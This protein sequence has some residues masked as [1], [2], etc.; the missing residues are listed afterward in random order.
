MKRYWEQ[1]KHALVR[2]TEKLSSEFDTGVRVIREVVEGL[3]VLI[4]SER[5]AQYAEQYD[6]KHYFVIPFTLTEPGFILHT[7]RCLPDGIPEINDLPKRRVFHLPGE[8]FEAL[9][10]EHLVES[11]RAL[12]GE[13]HGNRLSSL[14]SL[15]NDIDALDSK[16]TYGMLLVGGIAAIFN[17]LLGAGIAAKAMLPGIA[18]I[19][20]KYGLRP[21]GE[22]LTKS[23]VAAELKKA[24]DQV[25][26]QFSDSNTCKVVNPILQ[27]LELALRT[28]EQ[29]HDPL[30]DPNLSNAS[31]PSLDGER[32]RELTVRAMHHVYADVYRNKKLQK[33]ACIGPEDV[34]WFDVLFEG[35][36]DE[37]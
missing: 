14:E 9:L 31:I 32:W 3:P 1:S 16:L 12:A 33:Q 8:H 27:E 21:V 18:G 36:R 37:H 23:Q 26:A 17:P 34:R 24:E 20:N 28:T 13:H 35:Y 10:R 19:L 5:S 25:L 30:I 4:S 22:K 15:A 2:V 7:M 6:E 11:A 29:E